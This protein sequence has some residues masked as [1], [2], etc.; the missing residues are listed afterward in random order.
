M[1][2]P[3]GHCTIQPEFPTVKC[4]QILAAIAIAAAPSFASAQAP[5]GGPSA[6]TKKPAQLPADS[7][8]RARKFALWFYTSQSDSLFAHMDSTSRANYHSA[9]GLD[10]DIANFALNVGSE[11][12]V[13]EEKFI[14]RKGNRQY[15][16]KAIFSGDSAPFLVR[17]VIGTKGELMGMGLGPAAEAPP[18]DP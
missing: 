7:V 13:L 8:E 14:T 10:D 17:L 6:A 2:P 3:V 16:R 4:L 12:K 9:R 15:W 5:A 18:I 1:G 11:V